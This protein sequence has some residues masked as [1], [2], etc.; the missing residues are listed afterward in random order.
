[1]STKDD[2][3]QIRP[4]AAVL[5]DIGSG[6]LAA[7]LATQLAELGAAVSETGK[8]G[9]ITLKIEVAPPKKHSMDGA[10]IVSG[11]SVAK[12]PEGDD[13]APA[14]IFFADGSGNLTRDD[15]RQQQLPL[16]GLP[17]QKAATA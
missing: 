14:S 7:R 3:G 5:Q 2:D 1:V 11:V 9:S 17:G 4:F 8:K 16:I 15:P 12:I 6:K 13:A 10:L